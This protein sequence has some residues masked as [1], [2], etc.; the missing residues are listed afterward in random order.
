MVGLIDAGKVIRVIKI[1]TE[2]V[3]CEGVSLD[4]LVLLLDRFP[5]FKRL[6]TPQRGE[7]DTNELTVESLLRLAPRVIGAIL[8][9]GTGSPGNAEA[10]KMYKGLG[11]GHQVRLLK[12]IMDLTFPGGLGPFVEDLRAMGLLGLASEGGGDKPKANGASAGSG[13]EL[14]TSSSS[15]PPGSTSGVTQPP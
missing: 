3:T 1:G 6:V 10:E 14:A 2:D 5:E 8:A 9:A 4:G 11:I 13:R 15:S 7:I 12:E